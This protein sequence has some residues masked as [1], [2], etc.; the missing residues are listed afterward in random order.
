MVLP[1]QQPANEQNGQFIGQIGAPIVQPPA[2]IQPQHLPLPPQTNQQAGPP[3]QQP[4]QQPTA[5]SRP[6]FSPHGMIPNNG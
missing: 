5:M 3:S 6:P 2:Q 4:P 1:N